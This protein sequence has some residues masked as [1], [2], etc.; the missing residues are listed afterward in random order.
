M[1]PTAWVLM[2]MIWALVIFFAGRFFWMVLRLEKKG[3]N[4]DE[5]P[6]KP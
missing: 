2:L 1:T 3:R 4:D 5:P 6:D